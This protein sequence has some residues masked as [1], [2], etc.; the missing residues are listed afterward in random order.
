MILTTIYIYLLG[1][2]GAFISI[3]L[4]NRYELIYGKNSGRNKTTLLEAL[5]ASLLS[6]VFLL[7][8]FL[9]SSPGQKLNNWFKYGNKKE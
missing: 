1:Y 5:I 6:W 2:V 8:A 7:L 9:E 4:D 3:I